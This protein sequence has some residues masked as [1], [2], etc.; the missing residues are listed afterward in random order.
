VSHNQLHIKILRNRAFRNWQKEYP[1]DLDKSIFLF[2]ASLEPSCTVSHIS[3]ILRRKQFGH[4]LEER[5]Q[6]LINFEM[7]AK[8]TYS[9]DS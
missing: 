6:F 9:F 8:N 3:S 2:L 1:Q 4:L 7:K 5:H